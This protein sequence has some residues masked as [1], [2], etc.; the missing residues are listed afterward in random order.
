MQVINEGGSRDDGLAQL[1]FYLDGAHTKESMAACGHWFADSLL[2][3]LRRGKSSE[4]HGPVFTVKINKTET[5]QLI[6]FPL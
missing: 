4:Q 5:R 6:W 2:A 3:E 1:A